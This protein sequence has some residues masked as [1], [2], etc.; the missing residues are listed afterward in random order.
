MKLRTW[1]ILGL[2][3]GTLLLLTLL[4]G[5]D[6]LRRTGQIYG[7]VLSIHNSRANSGEALRGIETGIYVSSIFVRDFLLDP[8]Q[9]MAESYRRE[10]LTIR[11]SMEQDLSTL[12]GMQ[13]AAD[14]NLLVRLR[15]EI[16][17]YWDSFDPIF[18]WSPSQKLAF[19]SVFLRR[20][21][22]PRRTAVLD[23]A[24]EVKSLNSSGADQ[25]RKELG[26]SLA[27]FQRS[28]GYS[29]IAVLIL[30]VG[31]SIVSIIRISVLENRAEQQHI[32]TERAERELRRLSQQLVHAQEDERRNLSRELHD[33]VGQT[34]TALRVELGNLEKLRLGP[35]EPFR[36]HLEDA[37]G[38][39]A[40]T[41]QSVRSLA[42][43]LRPS[44]LD[45]LGLG[46]ALEWQARQFSRRTGIVVEVVTE[47]MSDELPEAYRTCLYRVVQ[48][49]LTNCARHSEARQIRIAMR[50]QN[51]R[52]CLAVQDDGKGFN[53]PKL[54]AAD[55][56]SAG[57]GLV[58]IEER[59][60]ELGGAV[61]L[62]SHPGQGTLLKVGIPLPDGAKV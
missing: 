6:A 7:S 23:I 32:L 30:G 26:V 13:T 57:L 36:I 42:S 40:Q 49:A 31:V 33:E 11:S 37:K 17:A 47:D 15:R 21:V 41:L 25:R 39:T 24:R 56:F 10:L 12:G 59:V 44:V 38:L 51:D 50:T 43:G 8:S 14:K 20:Q 48:E 2:G 29:F 28:G 9:L 53:D 54:R 4:F 27:Q 34:L 52:L 22:L 18:D 35:E 1:P 16:D 60:H 61:E 19:S 5:L 45:D 3:F 62:H 58:G 55:A 46:P